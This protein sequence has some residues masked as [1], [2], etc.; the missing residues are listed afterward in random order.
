MIQSDLIA[1]YRASGLSMRALAKRAGLPWQSVQH[2]LNGD[3]SPSVDRAEAIARA[4]GAR[5]ILKRRSKGTV[6]TPA[7]VDYSP[8]EQG[9]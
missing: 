9:G 1:L 7:T 2:W 5:L 4:L 8:S 3:T 6:G